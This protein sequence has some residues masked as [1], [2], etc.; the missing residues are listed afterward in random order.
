MLLLGG[1][2]FLGFAG[3][4]LLAIY[5]KTMTDDNK[6]LRATIDCAGQLLGCILDP[7]EVKDYQQD[8]TLM[9][10]DTQ[11]LLAALQDP[12]GKAASDLRNI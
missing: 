8:P 1:I 6:R 3:V 4:L 9:G 12:D 2:L 7:K 10:R 5:A 11:V